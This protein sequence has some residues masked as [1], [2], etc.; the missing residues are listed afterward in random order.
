MR[1]TNTFIRR[2]DDEAEEIPIAPHPNPTPEPDPDR[3]DPGIPGAINALSVTKRVHGTHADTR[4][5]FPFS[6]TITNSSLI[7]ALPEENRVTYESFRGWIYQF[8]ATS[9]EYERTTSFVD[10]TAGEARTFNLT[11]GQALV[12]DGIPVGNEIV[13]TETNSGNYHPRIDLRTNGTNRGYHAIA[14]ANSSIGTGHIAYPTGQTAHSSGEL[15]NVA[16][17]TNTNQTTPI[18][19]LITNNLPFILVTLASAGLVAIVVVSRKR[20][21]FE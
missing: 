20:R 12:F 8:N 9:G 16:A 1:F 21:A 15:S 14:A 18:T 17:F 5:A 6:G 2:T 10:F 3:T 13:M 11:H 19:G 4:D 7:N